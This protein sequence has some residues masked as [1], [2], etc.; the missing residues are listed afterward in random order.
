MNDWR[1]LIEQPEG[2]FLERKSAY[3]RSGS[4]G[5]IVS[6]HE[7]AAV[8]KP[9]EFV[10]LEPILREKGFVKNEHIRKDLGATELKPRKL[11]QR[12]VALGGLQPK[13]REVR[14]ALSLSTASYQPV[15]SNSC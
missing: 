14:T 15:S 9:P 5:I 3:D 7:K 10:D 8:E 13:R 4:R 1:R 12:S 2:Q 11:A 6:K